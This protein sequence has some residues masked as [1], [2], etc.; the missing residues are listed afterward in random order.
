MQ[1]GWNHSVTTSDLGSSITSHHQT[2]D[3]SSP[4]R[5]LDSNASLQG[6][7]AQRRNTTTTTITTGRSDV[8]SSQAITTDTP[9]ISKVPY[10]KR[11]PSIQIHELHS[12]LGRLELHQK[13]A[14]SH[15]AQQQQHNNLNLSAQ[16]EDGDTL[17]MTSVIQQRSDVANKILD[18]TSNDK[19][20]NL[21]NTFGQSV[22]HL[23]VIMNMTSLVRRL[24]AW[25]AHLVSYDRHGNTPLHIACERGF[26]DTVFALT[27]PLTYTE[28]CQRP[29]YI[30][31]QRTP[32]DLEIRNHAGQT[33]VQLALKQRH[34]V[35]AEYL[36]R[37]C[38]ANVGIQDWTNGDTMIHYAVQ[39][40]DVELLKFLV[41]YRSVDVNL[42]RYDG[43][44]ALDIAQQVNN[45]RMTSLL[46]HNG[47]VS[48]SGDV[49]SSELRSADSEA[50]ETSSEY[51]DIMINGVHVCQ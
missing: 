42:R 33:C 13:T 44:T 14:T 9:H 18:V 40:D 50:M 35:I 36:I 19:C 29:Y 20:L 45:R 31:F 16:D 15:A 41:S 6:K 48:S 17:L 38:N 30:P 26:I 8:M 25:G 12:I 22:L 37:Y 28:V 47:A 49:S 46:M 1:N 39:T 4:L 24:T 2:A 10:G 32:Q 3:S 51:D 27:T 43:A 23:A 21:K 34:Y 11:I 5:Q 7:P